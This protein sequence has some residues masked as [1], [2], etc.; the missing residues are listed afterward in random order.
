MK[1]KTYM[2]TNCR[3]MNPNFTRYFVY[4]LTHTKCTSLPQKFPSVTTVY[5]TVVLSTINIVTTTQEHFCL[6]QDL[7]LCYYKEKHA[8]KIFLLWSK[9]SLMSRSRALTNYVGSEQFWELDLNQV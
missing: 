5:L 7:K 4:L 1:E 6:S 8:G 2:E 9:M 3:N